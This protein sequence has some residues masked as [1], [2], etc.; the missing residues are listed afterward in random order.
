MI[1]LEVLKDVLDAYKRDFARRWD[2]ERYK[3]EAVKHFQEHWDIHAEAFGEMFLKATEKTKNLLMSRHHYPRGMIRDFANADSEAARAMFLHL[4][5]ETKDLF[6]RVEKFQADAEELRAKYDNGT[7]RQHYQTPN[8][9]STYLWLRYPDKYYIY[10]YSECRDA[11]EVL[12][13][14]PVPQRGG[15][16]ASLIVG[17]RL[18]DEICAHL[19]T[20]RELI[21]MLESALTDQCYPDRKLKT[22]TADVVFYISRFYARKSSE[23]NDEWFPKDYNPNIS[24]E[25]WLKLLADETVFTQESLQIMKRMKDIGGMATCSQLSARYGETP[26][27]YNRGSSSLAQRVAKATGCP[28]MEKDTENS[29][30]WPILYVG[31]YADKNTEGV[32]IWKL[33][34]ELSRAL[35]QVDLSHVPLYA[36]ETTAVEGDEHETEDTSD[37]TSEPYT[38]EDFLKEVF[39]SDQQLNTLLSLLRKKK[40]LILQGPPGVGKTFAARRLAYVMMG[41]K[42]DSR[43]EFVQFHQNYAYEDFVMGY[44]PDGEGFALKY[45]IFHRFCRRAE[46][47]PDKPFFFI[48]DEI[49]RGNL[50]KI[51]GELL[52]LIE[53]D[54]RGT[55]VS[56][57][58]GGEPFSVPPNVYIIG[59]MN[60]ADRSLALIDYAL[61]RRFSFFD[62][63]PG[64]HTD[65]FRAYQA[66]L[67][68]ETFDALIEQIT[69]LNREI[70]ADPSLGRGFRIGHSYF[71]GQTECTEEWL[72]EIVEYDI[73][74]TLGEY[75]FDEPA[76]LQRWENR[77]RSVFDD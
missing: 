35:D 19:K 30:W 13:S 64:F 45:G 73:L 56:L 28:L 8:A 46:E 59:M 5:D 27:F 2:E 22:L 18:Y 57:A 68:N 66:S 47:H 37:G 69:A 39:M 41:E 7:W 77:L 49:N 63:E 36:F 1:D 9:I 55:K 61:R 24:T 62:M 76:V 42:D 3:W 43:V 6:E 11:A 72:R 33:R 26:N 65:G 51:F 25:M 60:T 40:N 23:E 32:Y 75:W 52:M 21:G 74:P 34:E 53:K 31:K 70:A 48:I 71:C 14:D 29:K 38:K 16:T 50:S 10:K 20:D 4:F 12:R 17:Y 44:K 15:S 58:Y 54:Y 67:A